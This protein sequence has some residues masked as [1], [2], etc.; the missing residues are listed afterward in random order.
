MTTYSC[1]DVAAI[2]KDNG[3]SPNAVIN[4]VAVSTAESGRN[5]TAISSSYDY[6]LWQI[7]RIHFGTVGINQNNWSDPNVNARAAI[8]ISQNGA[9][10][11]PWCTCW[12]DP[13]PNCGHGYLPNPQAGSPAGNEVGFVVAQLGS[14]A[15]GTIGKVFTG[16]G[17]VESAWSTMDAFLG[18]WTRSQYG[19][20]QDIRAA[21]GRKF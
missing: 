20:L 16:P 5:N 11:A 9:N 1:Q 17:Q 21:I 14:G 6:G 7:N 8:A 15:G 19:Y 10:W 12:T 4:A 18:P 13:G 2:W 3:G